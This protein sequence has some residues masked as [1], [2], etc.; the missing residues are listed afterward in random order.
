MVHAD[1]ETRVGAHRVFSVVLVPSSVCPQP[2]S[3]EIPS[4]KSADIQRMLSRNVSVFSSSAALFEKLERKQNSLPED[5]NSNTD[6]KVN[7][8]SILNRLKSTYSR[9]TS[10][11]KSAMASTEYMDNRNSK[12]NNNSSVMNRLKTSYSRATSVRKPQVNTTGEENTTN[13]CTKQHVYTCTFS[14][15]NFC[16]SERILL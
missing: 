15:L 8:N 6:A 12:V 5:S 3:S 7:D 16:N 1:H 10:G 13:T 2:S 9:T 14:F 11:R 4:T